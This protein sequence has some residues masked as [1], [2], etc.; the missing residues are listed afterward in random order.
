MCILL[1]RLYGIIIILKVTSFPYYNLTGTSTAFAPWNAPQ[2]TQ[3]PNQT[4]IQ[5]LLHVQVHW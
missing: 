2:S 4:S 3:L 5:T 1:L